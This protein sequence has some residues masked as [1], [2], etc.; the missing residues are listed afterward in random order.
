MDADRFDVLA[1]RMGGRASRRAALGS[2]ATAGVLSA[3]G[4]G[5]AATAQGGT[6]TMAFVATVRQG[7]S[8]QQALT[9]GAARPGELRGELSFAL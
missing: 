2:A 9:P 4:F 6:C 5:R 1:K 8:A 3:L 7:A